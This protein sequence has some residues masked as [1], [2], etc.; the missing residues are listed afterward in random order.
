MKTLIALI[1]AACLSLAQANSVTVTNDTPVAVNAFLWTS[2]SLGVFN[3]VTLSSFTNIAP[4]TVTNVQASGTWVGAGVQDTNATFGA[5][6][7]VTST[8]TNAEAFFTN[9]AAFVVATPIKLNTNALIFLTP[10]NI[11]GF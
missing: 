3:S 11:S 8:S 2:N 5:R 7:L 9:S 1:I 10:T 6:L 4:H